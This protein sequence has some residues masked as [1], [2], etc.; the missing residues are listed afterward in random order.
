MTS[1]AC[2]ER[3]ANHVA[4]RTA[5]QGETH[6]AVGVERVVVGGLTCLYTENCGFQ[7][8]LKTADLIIELTVTGERSLL[9]TF[10]K[11]MFNEVGD[12]AGF[13]DIFAVLIREMTT[14]AQK[15]VGIGAPGLLAKRTGL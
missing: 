3:M 12:L 7:N 4:S 13:R 5:V 6:K 14:F 9:F 2:D 8:T 1:Q 11:M 10:L 15:V